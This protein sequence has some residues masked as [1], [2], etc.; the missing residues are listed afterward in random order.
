[1]YFTK[2]ICC[3]LISLLCICCDKE[4]TP[5]SNNEYLGQEPPGLIPKRFAPANLLAT[6][7][8][9]WHSS[10]MF[11]NDGGEMFF[12]KFMNNDGSML[13]NS[14]FVDDGEW[15]TPQVP[16]FA[17]TE[18]ESNPFYFP[19]ENTMY[20]ISYRNGKGIYKT[21][22]FNG[23]WTVPEKVEIPI[24]ENK[25]IGLQFSITSSGTIYFLLWISDYS[26]PPDIYKTELVNGIYSE[27]VSLG[28]II[29]STESEICPFIDPNEEYL[30]FS[31]N[32]S[33]GYGYHD[34]YISFKTSD[35]SWSTPVNMGNLIN[36]SSENTFP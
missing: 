31:S 28:S 20:F 23:I 19:D 26:M 21:N 17:L 4:D 8:W 33:G 36:S 5:D 32:R 35:N 27:P 24:P 22:R 10:P 30:I 3:V 14:I 9:C 12:G 11:S 16:S 25:V 7:T 18:G 15:S 1:M 34:L 13:L 2:L 6:N 29:N